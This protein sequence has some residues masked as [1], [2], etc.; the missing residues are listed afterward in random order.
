MS[1][2][3]LMLLARLPLSSKEKK[4]LKTENHNND[5]NEILRPFSLTELQ[6][7]G[8]MTCS[9]RTCVTCGP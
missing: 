9:W 5:N 8:E 6:D 7:R 2:T 4:K 3:L 1:W